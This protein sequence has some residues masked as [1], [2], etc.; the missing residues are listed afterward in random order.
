M[1]EDHTDPPDS[2]RKESDAHSSL[3][4]AVPKV[5]RRPTKKGSK[6]PLK[7]REPLPFFEQDPNDP[8]SDLIITVSLN[9]FGA[10]TI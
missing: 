8:Y 3:R 5:K 9:Y 2:P 10:C 6:S 7:F 4:G 1:S